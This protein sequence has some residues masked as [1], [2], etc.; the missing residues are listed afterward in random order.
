MGKA[1]C[2]LAEALLNSFLFK[3]GR[4]CLDAGFI[5]SALGSNQKLKTQ[6]GWKLLPD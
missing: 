5:D 1:S 4:V 6:P 3:E 2:W